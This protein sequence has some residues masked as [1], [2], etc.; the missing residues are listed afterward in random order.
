MMAG[1]G[2]QVVLVPLGAWVTML[3]GNIVATSENALRSKSHEG[4]R[5]GGTALHGDDR[6]GI[7]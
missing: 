4:E 1:G 5:N 3:A 6:S 7:W 2:R